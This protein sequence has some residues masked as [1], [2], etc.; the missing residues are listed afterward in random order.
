M[1]ANCLPTSSTII[2]W[3]DVDVVRGAHALDWHMMLNIL[4]VLTFM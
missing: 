3:C 1:T 2:G 4:H